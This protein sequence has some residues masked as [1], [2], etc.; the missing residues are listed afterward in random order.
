MIDPSLLD[1]LPVFRELDSR[2]RDAVAAS[3]VLVERRRGECFWRAGDPVKGILVL[4]EGSVRMLRT[5]RDGRQQVI[6][7]EGPGVM[8]GEVGLWDGQRYPATAEALEPSRAV[9][10]TPEAVDAALAADVRFARRLLG[11]LAHR[12]R[13][14]VDRVEALST[15]DVRTRLA[16]HLLARAD[17]SERDGSFVLGQTQTALAEELG[18]V[19]EVVARQLSELRRDGVLESRGRGRYRVRDRRTLEDMAAG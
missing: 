2:I 3:S 12:V 1:R 19:R 10:V 5:S 4:L 13:L 17:S 8:L 18:T 15:L 16:R 14:L 11:N 6:H 7:S 9:L